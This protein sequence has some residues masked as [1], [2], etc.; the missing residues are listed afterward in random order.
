MFYN[1]IINLQ[2]NTNDISNYN[3]SDSDQLK[4]LN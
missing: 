2:S 3:M 1:I 4:L